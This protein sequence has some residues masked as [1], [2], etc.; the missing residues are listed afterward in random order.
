MG[1]GEPGRLVGVNG[2]GLPVGEGHP[3]AV[4]TD[5]EVYLLLEL[6]GEGF[7]YEWLAEKFE[8]SKGCVQKICTGLRRAQVPVAWRRI[9]TGGG[10]G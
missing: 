2:L 4:L 9:R 5:E 8:V 3:R 10:E 7:S 1:R 6:R